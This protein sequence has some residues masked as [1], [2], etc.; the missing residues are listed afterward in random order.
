MSRRRASFAT[1]ATRA[2][3]TPRKR[4][5]SP[6]RW[7]ELLAIRNISAGSGRSRRAQWR[8]AQESRMMLA[9]IDLDAF[10]VPLMVFGIFV[11]PTLGGAIA[12][13]LRHR[14]RVL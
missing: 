9:K 5:C 1:P 3:S 8:Q 2:R 6:R 7:P 14:E 11:L 10:I 12:Y 13:F 4:R